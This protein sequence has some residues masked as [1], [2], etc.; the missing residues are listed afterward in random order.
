MNEE[1]TPLAVRIVQDRK[2][3]QE[4]KAAVQGPLANR[5]PA[6]CKTPDRCPMGDGRFA[7]S[8]SVHSQCLVLCGVTLNDR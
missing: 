1:V 4:L 6:Q 7:A 8:Q 2:R 5:V 3:D